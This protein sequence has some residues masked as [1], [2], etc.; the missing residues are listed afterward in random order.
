M[1]T[2]QQAAAELG[3]STGWIRQLILSDRLKAEKIG[4]DWLIKPKDLEAV[5]G[6][7]IGRPKKQG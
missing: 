4:R 2:T 7:P 5:R 1:F 3:V 6:L